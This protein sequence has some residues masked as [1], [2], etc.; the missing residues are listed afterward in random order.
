LAL[1][2]ARGPPRRFPSLS[3]ARP[4]ETGARARPPI[5]IAAV[6]LRNDLRDLGM[7]ASVDGENFFKKLE[8][9]VVGSNDGTR[10][11]TGG[12]S[13]RRWSGGRVIFY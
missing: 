5:P 3:P 8:K 4:R 9:G 12:K 2:I 1:A 6:F 7:L 11:R 10:Y 13:L